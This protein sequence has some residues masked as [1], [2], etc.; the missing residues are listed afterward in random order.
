MRWLDFAKAAGIAALVLIIDRFAVFVVVG[1]WATFIE[2]GRPHSYYQ[3]AVIPIALWSTRI[4]KT[5][6]MFG[7]AWLPAK[8]NRQRDTILFSTTL[9]VF[10]VLFDLASMGFA[11]FFTIRVALTMSLKLVAALAGGLIAF[12]LRPV[13]SAEPSPK[14]NSVDVFQSVWYRL[15][16]LLCVVTAAASWFVEDVEKSREC[17]REG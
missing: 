11:N 7:T 16:L 6:L 2:S 4:F 13:V 8:R 5:L 12:R 9:V 10:Y 14:A 3:T 17:A 15:V 1:A